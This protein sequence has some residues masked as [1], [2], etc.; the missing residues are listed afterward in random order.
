[1][2]DLDVRDIPGGV[3]V[4]IR[5]TPRSSRAQVGGVV[6]GRLAVRVTAPP[7]DQAA[8]DAIVELLARTL[9]LPRSAVTVVAGLRSK[10]K[11]VELR[12]VTAD[13]VRRLS[14][15]ARD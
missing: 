9:K 8:N 1:V 15:N 5:V 12:G 3:S 14:I 2:N 11:I 7:V 10:Q 4:S 6:R 13:A